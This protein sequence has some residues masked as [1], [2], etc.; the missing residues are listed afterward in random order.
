M[1]SGH[2]PHPLPLP[3]AGEGE[4]E[5]GTGERSCS[6]ST[7]HGGEGWGEGVALR[8]AER[9]HGSICTE[10]RIASSMVVR[11]AP[12]RSIALCSRVALP[13]CSRAIC[14]NSIGEPRL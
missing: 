6:L 11:P 2:C 7:G 9:R 1:L 12:A 8:H 13:I 3:R 5:G 10:T 4:G 14:T